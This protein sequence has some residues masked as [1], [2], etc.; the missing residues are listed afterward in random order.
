MIFEKWFPVGL[1]LWCC[2][3]SCYEIS[4]ILAVIS[5]LT[6]SDCTMDCS[7]NKSVQLLHFVYSHEVL[8]VL[9]LGFTYEKHSQ[10]RPTRKR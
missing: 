6:L 9:L 8:R 3:N 5:D 7:K 4:K 1:I 2:H 10:A